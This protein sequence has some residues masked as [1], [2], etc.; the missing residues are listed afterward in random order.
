MRHGMRRVQR[1]GSEG[2]PLETTGSARVFTFPNLGYHL[3]RQR[4][5]TAMWDSVALVLSVLSVVISAVLA[6][7][8]VRER[9]RML[10]FYLKQDGQ[11]VFLEERKIPKDELE[12]IIQIQMQ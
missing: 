12:T 9:N 3:S 2:I 10:R 8:S 7:L 4:R 6:V 5:T 11:R 1:T